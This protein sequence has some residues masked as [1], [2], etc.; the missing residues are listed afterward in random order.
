MDMVVKYFIEAVDAGNLVWDLALVKIE[1][2]V[3]E[4]EILM[5]VSTV[6]TKLR[7]C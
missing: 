5:C 2:L 3:K 1:H 4:L 6:I 7:S